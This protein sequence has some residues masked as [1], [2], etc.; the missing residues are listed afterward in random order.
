MEG[1]LQ[2]TYLGD[3]QVWPICTNILYIF[4]MNLFTGCYFIAAGVSNLWPKV[5][6]SSSISSLRG[7]C[8]YHV[9]FNSYGSLSQLYE[10]VS[11]KWDVK[12]GCRLWFFLKVILSLVSVT[13][14]KMSICLIKLDY[15]MSYEISV[16]YFNCMALYNS[17]DLYICTL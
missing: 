14:I 1:I 13:R 8:N 3:I 2:C 11:H 15:E 17:T 6:R 12:L 9:V 16:K 7:C 5:G 10:K 4:Y